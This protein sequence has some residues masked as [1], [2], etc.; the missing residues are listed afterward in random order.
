M[1]LRWWTCTVTEYSYIPTYLAINWDNKINFGLCTNYTGF[2]AVTSELIFTMP[3]EGVGSCTYT[4][5]KRQI[6]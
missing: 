2:P 3:G 5:M 4:K 6:V 1:Q